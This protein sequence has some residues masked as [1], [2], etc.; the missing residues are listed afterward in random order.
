MNDLL[1]LSLP[2]IL[3]LA[4]LG[5]WRWIEARRDRAE[6]AAVYGEPVDDPATRYAPPAGLGILFVLA[7]HLAV[8]FGDPWL[9]AEG[10]AASVVVFVLV[11]ASPEPQEG[12]WSYW[13]PRIGE[14]ATFCMAGTIVLLL[15]HVDLPQLQVTERPAWDP[16][17][18]RAFVPWF[19]KASTELLSILYCALGWLGAIRDRRADRRHRREI[20]GPERAS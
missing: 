16:V 1:W 9:L 12:V 13:R 14:Y 7:I 20:Y 17:D 6:E 2:V 15:F 5:A 3:V 19:P 8:V 11:A 10:F 18:E 4:L